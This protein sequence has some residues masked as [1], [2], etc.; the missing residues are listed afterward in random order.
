MSQVAIIGILGLMMVC[1]SSSAAMLMMGGDDEKKTGPTGPTGP[2]SPGPTGPLS[3]LTVG[4]A[5][6]CEA[7]DPIDAPNR[8][9]YRYVG[10]NTLR[11]YPNPTIASSWDPNWASFTK[12]A[13]CTEVTKGTT[14]PHKTVSDATVGSAWQC[15]ASDPIGAPNRAVYRYMGNDTFRHYPNPTIASSWD[16]NWTS[17][18]KVP[19]CTGVIN[20]APLPHKTVSDAEAG[21][22]WQCEAGD[23][24]DAPNR[25]V[26]MYMGN[27]TFRY[28]PN[29][30]IASSWDSNWTS[31]G[32]VPDCTG[33]INGA[34][35]PMKA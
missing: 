24:M 32:K 15:E 31:F 27:D 19:D 6:Q 35:L 16:S 28:Y 22:S 10:D 29:P 23:P 3:S 26:Y 25:A 33:V 2:S 18:G 34:P 5:V 1:S 30:T 17:F 21:S 12:I 8:A 11:H 4:S 20:G 14:L 13:D 7:G 9:V